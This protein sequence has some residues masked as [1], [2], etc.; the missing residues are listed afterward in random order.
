[1][2]NQSSSKIKTVLAISMAVLFVVSLTTVAVEARGGGA[3]ISGGYSVD[4]G[5]Y[6]NPL[7]FPN[8]NPYKSHNNKIM[9]CKPTKLRWLYLLVID[10]YFQ[11]LDLLFSSEFY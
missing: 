7:Y 6:D 10:N 5:I 9:R 3:G 2:L 8:G 11:L 4:G 1:M